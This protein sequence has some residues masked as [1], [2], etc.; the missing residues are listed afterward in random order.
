MECHLL[1]RQELQ[2]N[3]VLLQDRDKA[4]FFL[5]F[6]LQRHFTLFELTLKSIQKSYAAQVFVYF[7]EL[8]L[9]TKF[10]GKKTEF[11]LLFSFELLYYSTLF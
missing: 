7:T 1:K 5:Y 8:E 10:A 4:Q 6:T 9:T 2:N 3:F 11:K